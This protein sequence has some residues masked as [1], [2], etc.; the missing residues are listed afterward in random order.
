MAFERVSI[1]KSHETFYRVDCPI[2]LYPNSLK[3]IGGDFD[4][5]KTSFWLW[6]HTIEKVLQITFE[7]ETKCTYQVL[8]NLLNENSYA[9]AWDYWTVALA[10]IEE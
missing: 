8:T 2:I 1:D 6:N 5:H 4:L 7:W 9:K 3:K 10:E